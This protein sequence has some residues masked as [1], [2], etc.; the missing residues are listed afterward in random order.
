MKTY[1]TARED[2]PPIWLG[3]VPSRSF[4]M[5]W[6]VASFVAVEME[7]GIEP[8]SELLLSRLCV[9]VS[10]SVGVCQ[11]LGVRVRDARAMRISYV[12]VDQCRD[13]EDRREQR[14]GELVVLG[15]EDC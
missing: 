8:W 10:E 4:S 3:R 12:H 2:M 15:I 14:S 9:C 11:Y 13:V 7:C 6:R 5:S 1:N